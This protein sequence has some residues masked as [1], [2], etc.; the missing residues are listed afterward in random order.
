MTLLMDSVNNDVSV[1]LTTFGSVG[2]RWHS[3]NHGPSNWN[4]PAIPNVESDV[5]M[6]QTA[7]MFFL[8][9]DWGS[10]PT[11]LHCPA[12]WYESGCFGGLRARPSGYRAVSPTVSP[13]YCSTTYLL[14]H[15]FDS[16]FLFT[17]G[18]PTVVL[19]LQAQ[20]KSTPRL[21][22]IFFLGFGDQTSIF[23]LR[24]SCFSPNQFLCRRD[25]GHDYAG[26]TVFSSE[27]GDYW[28]TKLMSRINITYPLDA[29][30]PVLCNTDKPS[31]SFTWGQI[32]SCVCLTG[33]IQPWSVEG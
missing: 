6:D 20:P 5:I 27:R 17:Q 24:F 28:E 13:P 22:M 9:F 4:H 8:V 21:D 16:R 18:W 14:Q 12:R 26:T 32:T 15:N 31:L 29:H 3:S 19:P 25:H 30:T 1:G 10:D 11:E 7:F 23:I 33:P 2:L